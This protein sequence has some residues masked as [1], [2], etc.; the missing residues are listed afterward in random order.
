MNSIEVRQR[1]MTL[2]LEQYY[3]DLR[4]R[5]F[6]L[7][8]PVGVGSTAASTASASTIAKSPFDLAEEVK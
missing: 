5:G 3:R 2:L 4:A 6:A 1:V 7:P 8:P